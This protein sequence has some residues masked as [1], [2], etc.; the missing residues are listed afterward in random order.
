MY[1]FNFVFQLGT[2]KKRNHLNQRV[3]RPDYKVA[4][5]QLVSVIHL[6]STLETAWHDTNVTFTFIKIQHKYLFSLCDL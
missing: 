3:K 1:H 4:Y 2:N 6:G 5:V